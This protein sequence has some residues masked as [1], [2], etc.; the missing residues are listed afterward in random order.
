M[1]ILVFISEDED[2]EVETVLL[3]DQNRNREI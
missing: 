1:E 2:V 3:T